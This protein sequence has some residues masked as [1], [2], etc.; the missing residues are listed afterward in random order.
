MDAHVLLNSDTE[1]HIVADTTQRII[2]VGD[3]HGCC[4][5]LREL[6]EEHSQPDDLL[7]L[8]GDMVNKG[9]KSREVLSVARE[10]QCLAVV[11][12]H[13]LAALRGHADR[14]GGKR[15]EASPSFAWTDELTPE[16]LTYLRNLP[17]TIR[18][19][20]QNSIVVHAGLV[21]GV[22][23][24]R[25]VAYDMVCMREL[26]VKTAGSGD[27]DTT[28]A[29]EAYETAQPGTETK[30]WASLWPGPEHVYFGHDA[31]RKYQQHEFATGLDTGCLYGG[32]LTAA[33]IEQG[34][35]PRIVT[36]K[37]HKQYVVPLKGPYSYTY[38]WLGLLQGRSQRLPLLLLGCLAAAA[39]AAYLYR[40]PRAQRGRGG[41]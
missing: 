29:Y 31:N 22:A 9:P 27:E 41:G 24:E 39:G 11:G 16:D 23:L 3:I 32:H 1:K 14:Q 18:L 40:A 35:R 38:P 4:D 7:I 15:P 10:M 19:P 17:F 8:A 25:Q 20:R 6:M 28:L 33:I 37:A 12:N 34:Q 2:I 30:A 26:G 21:P 13:E 5:E 36:V